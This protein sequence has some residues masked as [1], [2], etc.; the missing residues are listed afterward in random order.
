MSIVDVN[1]LWSDDGW[2]A[3]E[4]LALLLQGPRGI[5]V[6]TVTHTGQYRAALG[7]A[8]QQLPQSRSDKV[9]TRVQSLHLWAMCYVVAHSWSLEF[10]QFRLLLA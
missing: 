6:W 5:Q 2:M 4:D 3:T 8:K 1:F 10:S 7:I 9:A